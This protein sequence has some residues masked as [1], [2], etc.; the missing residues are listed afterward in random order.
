MVELAAAGRSNASIANELSVSLKTV[1]THLGRAYRKL[2]IPGR[3]GLAGA[4]AG[5]PMPNHG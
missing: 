1:E 2:A 4:L 5:D 3:D